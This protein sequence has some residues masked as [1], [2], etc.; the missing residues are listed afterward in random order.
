MNKL[1]R[2]QV[3][4]PVLWLLAACSSGG[5]EAENSPP[6]AVAGED[7][8][9]QLGQEAGLD[10]SESY[11]PDGDP[12]TFQ[13]SFD[14]RPAGSHA[15]LEDADTAEAWFTPDVEGRYVVSLVVN[16]GKVDSAP[17]TVTVTVTGGGQN[18]PPVA[19]AGPDRQVEVGQT[20][21]LDGS[22]SSDPDGD[23]LSYAWSFDSIPQGS[24]ARLSGA[25]TA[26]PSFQADVEG[27]YV[28]KLVVSDGQVD[29]QPDTVTITATQAP[30]GGGWSATYGLEGTEEFED[31]L[32]TDDGGFVGAGLSDSYSAEGDADAVVVKIDGTGQVAWAYAYGGSQDDMAIDIEPAPDGGFVVAG[33]T[34]SFG[35]GGYDAWLLKIGATGQVEWAR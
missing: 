19:D 25:D 14:S 6:V 23:Q 1:G 22:S 5:G 24:S 18:N 26:T 11:D 4:L 21:T 20:V 12:I 9:I 32:A 10:G 35:A 27:Q 7:F 13:W 33:W 31:I 16:D 34:R 2:V 15:Q 8:Q 29:S 17:D 3:W 28:V 30:S